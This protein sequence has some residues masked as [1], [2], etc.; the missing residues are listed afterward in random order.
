MANRVYG[1]L[2]I[3]VAVIIVL[4]GCATSSSTARQI[5]RQ[6]GYLDGLAK[7]HMSVSDKLAEIGEKI[8]QGKKDLEALKQAHEAEVVEDVI[9]GAVPPT[10]LAPAE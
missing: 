1:A 7:A 9:E 8:E 10:P 3:A 2:A 5:D 6:I 4:T